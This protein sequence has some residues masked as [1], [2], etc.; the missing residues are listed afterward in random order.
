MVKLSLVTAP[1]TRLVTAEELTVHSRIDIAEEDDY[2]E[3]LI[4]AAEAEAE[5]YTARKFLT[6]TWDQYCD[7]FTDPLVLHFPPLS[8][9]TSVT[10]IDAD[11]DTQTLS[12]DVYET[13]SQL[14]SGVVRRKYDD[15]NVLRDWPTDVRTHEDVVIVRFVCGYGDPEDV[16][17]RIKQA[18]RLHATHYFRYREGQKMTD[19]WEN[20][21]SPFRVRGF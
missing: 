14:G 18:I 5:E 8:S 9:V 10:Y 17:E 2:V 11:G 12:T 21:L 16:D 20:L 19:S 6:Q 4:D 1:T 15:N 3:K 13:G 7:G